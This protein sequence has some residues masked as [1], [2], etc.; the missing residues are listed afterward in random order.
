MCLRTGRWCAISIG[1]FVQVFHRINHSHREKNAWRRATTKILHIRWQPIICPSAHLHLV[2]Y[3]VQSSFCRPSPAS[4]R[5]AEGQKDRERGIERTREEIAGA[6]QAPALFFLWFAC[7]DII[8]WHLPAK[9]WMAFA[10][11]WT[12]ISK[13]KHRRVRHWLFLY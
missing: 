7:S 13:K 10:G 4:E 11:S 6:F 12:R 3:L 8:G 1:P 5:T 9:W 2:F